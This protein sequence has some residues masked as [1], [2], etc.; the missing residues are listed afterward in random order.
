M[1]DYEESREK[2]RAALF[3][4]SVGA[5]VWMSLTGLGTVLTVVFVVLKATH[6]IDWSWWLV[7]LPVIAEFVIS[8]S[9]FFAGM[10]YLSRKK[11]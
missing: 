2:L 1:S 4:I 9:I 7:F 3:A 10:I 5:A 6:Y 11:F 8:L